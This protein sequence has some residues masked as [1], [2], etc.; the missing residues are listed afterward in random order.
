M[1]NHLPKQAKQKVK[2]EYWMRLGVVLLFLLGSA[3]LGV[4]ILHTPTYVVISNQIEQYQNSFA[5]ASARTENFQAAEATVRQNNQRIALVFAN[6]STTPLRRYYQAVQ[7]HTND[8]I[9]VTGFSVRREEDRD[10]P[11]VMSITGIA[12]TREVL[13]EFADQLEADDRFSKAELPI[14]NLASSRDIS[15]SMR[16]TP[17]LTSE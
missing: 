16:L 14:S 5:A 9:Q 7:S 10:A 8:A 3:M 4:A 12:A 11:G 15:F 17:T 6:A 13:A 1:L 2:Q